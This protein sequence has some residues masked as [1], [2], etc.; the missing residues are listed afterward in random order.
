MPKPWMATNWTDEG[1]A[2]WHDDGGQTCEE[3]GQVPPHWLQNFPGWEHEEEWFEHNSTGRMEP[4]AWGIVSQQT[5]RTGHVGHMIQLRVEHTGRVSIFDG[6]HRVR[7]DA[8]IGVPLVPIYVLYLG[9]SQRR[10]RLFDHLL[11]DDG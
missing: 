5:E 3:E 6:N 10:H 8:L 9:N 11:R 7:I 1:P 4:R 2:N